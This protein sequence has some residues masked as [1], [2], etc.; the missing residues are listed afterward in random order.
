M[1]GSDVKVGVAYGVIPA[2]D[3]SS[4][5]KKD[6]F[7]VERS[8]LVSATLLSLDKYEYVVH[9]SE[10]KLDTNFQLAKKGSRNVGFLVSSDDFKN[11]GVSQN[12]IYWLARPQDIVAEYVELEPIWVEREKREVEAQAK[13]EAE[14]ALAEQQEKEAEKRCNDQIEAMKSTLTSIMGKSAEK[15]SASSL[16]GTTYN[17]REAHFSFDLQT[18]SV[19]VEKVLQAQDMLV[20]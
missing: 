4:A 19:L 6:K 13:A 9:R 14:R 3:Y 7:R 16:R 11:A 2:W 15:V 18:L 17:S 1:K 20:K 5:E 10:N 12:T 8:Q